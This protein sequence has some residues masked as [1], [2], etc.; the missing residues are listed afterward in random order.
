MNT[1]TKCD[2][3][4]ILV[5]DITKMLN[6]EKPVVCLRGF[7]KALE[8]DGASGMML[9]LDDFYKMVKA[10]VSNSDNIEEL[11]F[12]SLEDY[13][14]PDTNSLILLLR[15]YEL[16][17]MNIYVIAHELF[18]AYQEEKED[19]SENKHDFLKDF[20]YKAHAFSKWFLCTYTDLPSLYDFAMF[21][22]LFDN[23]KI[24]AIVKENIGEWSKL[25]FDIQNDKEA[26]SFQSDYPLKKLANRVHHYLENNEIYMTLDNIK[27]K[28]MDH[29]GNNIKYSL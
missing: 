28:D 16:S 13:H 9:P 18:H 3:L 26:Y 7:E 4:E 6:I 21:P 23:D 27:I 14:K 12:G 5:D 29:K 20:E 8:A 25:Y 11:Y 1:E 22:E 24:N 15:N 2:V 19:L 10:I 17:F